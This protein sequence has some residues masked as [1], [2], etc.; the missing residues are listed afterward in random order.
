MYLPG[1]HGSGRKLRFFFG[2]WSQ[3]VEQGLG[4]VGI[5]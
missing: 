5:M 2:E 3:L 4:E 1:G